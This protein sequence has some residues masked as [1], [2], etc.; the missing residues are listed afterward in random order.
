MK[1]PKE[2]IEIHSRLND[3]KGTERKIIVFDKDDLNINEISKKEVIYKINNYIAIN[4]IYEDLFLN[5]QSNTAIEFSKFK[6][7]CY[8]KK[9]SELRE[10]ENSWKD[11]LRIKSKNKCIYIAYYIGGNK[12]IIIGEVGTLTNAQFNKIESK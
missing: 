5:I 12:D 9:T 8:G 6:Y 1:T 7:L 3:A 10:V 11:I 2:I 4:W